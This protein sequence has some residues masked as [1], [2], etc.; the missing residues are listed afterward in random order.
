MTPERW[1]HVTEV[2][3]NALACDPALRTAFLERA[4]A[5]EADVREEVDRL[6]AAHQAAGPFGDAPVAAFDGRG[7]TDDLE[8]ALH[9]ENTAVQTGPDPDAPPRR[10]HRFTWIVWAASVVAVVAIVQG[11]AVLVRDRGATPDVGWIEARRAGGW[12]VARVD[13]AGPAAGILEPGDRLVGL[14]GIPPFGGGGLRVHRRDLSAGDTYRLAIDRQ[15]NRLETT[16]TVAEGPNDLPSRLAYFFVSLVWC[17]VGLFIGFARPEHPVARLAFG[18]AVTTGLGYLLT[19]VLRTPGLTHPLHVVLGFHFFSRFPTGRPVTG[20]WRW[21][22]ILAY[23]VAAVPMALAWSLQTTLLA[24][25]VP[26]AAELVSAR[27]S[28]FAL[29]GPLPL[30]L[31]YA[32]LVG[33]VTAAVRN[34]RALTDENERRRVQWVA[35]GSILSLTPQIV[36]SVAEIIFGVPA[37]AARLGLA[38]DLCS[39]GIP[40]VV[41]YA[42]VKHRVFDIK[43]VVRRG[44]RYL[45]ARRALQLAVAVP[46]VALAYTVFSHRHLTI[47]ALVTETSAYLYWLGAAGLALRFRR[48]IASWLDRRFFREEYDRERFVLGLLE[49]VRKVES[50]SELSRLASDRLESALH[51]SSVHVWYREPGELAAASSSDPLLTPPDFPSGRRWLAWLEQHGTATPPP[52]GAEAGLSRD[53]VRWF[54]RRGISLIVPMMDAGD[55]LVGALLLGGKKSEEPYSD[56]DRRLLDA[57]AKQ[58]AVVRE[59]LRLRARVHDEVRGRHDVLARLDGGLPDLLKECPACG[60][61]FDGDAERC[62]HDGQSLRL[63]LPVARTID[64][65]YRLDRLVGKGGMGAVYE[66]RDLRL[67]RSV[68]VKIMLSRAFGEQAALRRFRREARAAAHLDHPNIVAVHD[69]G[70]LEGEGAYLVMELVRGRTLR[71]ELDRLAP[72]APGTAAEWFGPMLD[73]AAAAHAHGIVH[74]DLKP[75]NV[76]GRRDD[77][78]ALAVKILDLGL[79]KF[80]SGGGLET[81]T[82]TTDGL[83]M[84]TPAYMSPEQILGRDVDQRTDI[85]ALAVMLAE[86]LTGQRPFQGGTIPDLLLAQRQ[87]A[88]R[89][90]GSSQQA[91]AVGDLL[92]QCLAPDPRDRIASAATLRAGLIPLLGACSDHDF[93]IAR[94]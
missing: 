33:M 23:V 43:V 27:E 52:R 66:A 20:L 2:F 54:D 94:P 67:D 56:A 6:L 28:L 13:P 75:E 71:D 24:R 57:I 68:A 19:A 53:D 15:G 26:G 70:A 92:R 29:R 80:R 51:P 60:A 83:V 74:R 17:V 25:G 59:N 16:L 12:F 44:V 38:A 18:A 46:A 86:A 76:I 82:M 1:R 14:N 47:A 89:L 50:M 81:G 62:G 21:L 22:L 65:K 4:C 35:Y 49:D 72:M 30:Y 42:V 41:A 79:V 7:L 3:H 37:A 61:C 69:Y 55:R 77:A 73:G 9:H 31:F 40:L 91:R 87:H 93:T 85:F 63:S 36:L 34:Y 8:Q 88:Y 10:R 32:S 78:G 48:S 84:G 39:I 45:L 11:A 64:G 58:A 90:P 5:D